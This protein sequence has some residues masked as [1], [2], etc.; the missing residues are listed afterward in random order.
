M[1]YVDEVLDRVIRENPN[2]PEFHQAV[3]EVLESLRR[4]FPLRT[5]KLALPLKTAKRPCMNYEIG[6]CLGPCGG[7]CTEAEYGEAVRRVLAFLGGNGT[8]L[9]TIIGA[10]LIACA[11]ILFVILKKRAA[12]K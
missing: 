1:S 7:K 10:S 11:G 4:L 2:E 3:K 6:K 9:F 12:S 8:M 5:C